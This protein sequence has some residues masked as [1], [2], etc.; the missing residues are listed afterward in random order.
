[1]S[2]N[3]EMSPQDAFFNLNPAFRHMPGLALG[4][5]DSAHQVFFGRAGE[6]VV[7]VKPFTRTSSHGDLTP[8]ARAEHE[9][10]MLEKVG[11]IGLLTLRPHKVIDNKDGSVAYLL[12]N[13][14][15]DLT[16]MS[17]VVQKGKD[18]FSTRVLLQ[19]T[20]ETLAE[21]HSNG[22]SH[23]D[24]QIKNFG[25]LP[26]DKKRIAVFDLERAGDTTT[27]HG[28]ADPFQHDLDSLVQSLAYKAYGGTNSN[29]ASNAVYDH[30][31]EPYM[32]NVGG[33][34]GA[35]VAE[36]MSYK[37]IDLHHAKHTELHG[38]RMAS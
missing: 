29:E 30:V 20:A 16:T 18:N 9:Q 32:L 21:L 24:A 19:R 14:E 3:N 13:Y 38:Q 8:R 26:S 27:K 23:G 10:A 36:A 33:S 12:T 22:I 6:R 25:I 31:I 34:L 5:T 11:T 28:K 17:A 35:D 2:R 15:P 4:A 37:A 1:M 7:A